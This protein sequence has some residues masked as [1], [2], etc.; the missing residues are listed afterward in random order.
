MRRDDILD[1]DDWEVFDHF[2]GESSTETNLAVLVTL[3]NPGALARREGAAASFAANV[4]PAMIESKVY[5]GLAAKL[6]DAL[7]GQ[8]VEADIT[9][10]EPRKWMPANGTTSIASDLGYVIGG[11]GLMAA[12][13]WAIMKGLKARK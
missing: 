1:H 3:K 10:V 5:E 4:A 8:N 11:T 9:V 13:A 2:D 7:A 6:Q 12:F